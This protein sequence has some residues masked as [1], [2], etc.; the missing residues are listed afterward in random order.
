MDRLQSSDADAAAVAKTPNRVSLADIEAEIA[1]ETTF[2]IAEALDGI[3]LL[4]NGNVP[5]QAGVVFTNLRAMTV[6]IV[7]THSGFT[8][9]GKSAPADPLN[10]DAELGKK[11]ARE[12]AIRQLWPFMGFTLSQKLAGRI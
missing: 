4:P 7:T 1:F 2:T 6:C 5:G 9:I 11:Y 3:S 12:D 10:F 8:V